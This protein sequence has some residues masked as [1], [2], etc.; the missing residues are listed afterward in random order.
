MK[1]IADP[2]TNVELKNMKEQLTAAVFNEKQEPLVFSVIDLVRL[3]NALSEDRQ[4]YRELHKTHERVK[5][6]LSS[7]RQ[8]FCKQA[9]NLVLE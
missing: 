1:S 2:I 5:R 3:V 8:R 9:G 6:S 4:R 7:F